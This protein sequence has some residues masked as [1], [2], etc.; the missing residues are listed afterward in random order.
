M[1]AET[2]ISD[3]G[4]DKRL[5]D[6]GLSLPEVA[7][8]AGAYI[9]ALRTGNVVQTS[10]QL[11]L[12]DGALPATGRLGAEVSL[13]QGYELARQCILGALAAV[14]SVTGSLDDI[15]QVVKVTG[16]VSSAVDFYDQPKVVNGASELLGELFGEAGRH[17]RSAV[18]VAALPLNAPVEIELQVLLRG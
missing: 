18:G 6:L 10:G 5:A 14:K 12:V 8:P 15:A 7:T 1:E 3:L 4:V 11:P 2:R 16:F 17:S 13:E 9:P